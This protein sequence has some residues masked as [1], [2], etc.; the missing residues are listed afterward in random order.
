MENID[1]NIDLLYII[2]TKFY[3]QSLATR[4]QWTS[5]SKGHISV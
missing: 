1:E 4:V 3:S 2:S 5:I